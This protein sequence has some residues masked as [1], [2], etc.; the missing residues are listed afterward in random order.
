MLRRK[1]LIIALRHREVL[2][3]ELLVAAVTMKGCISL[4]EDGQQYL[5]SSS[6]HIWFDFTRQRLDATSSIP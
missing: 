6:C 4:Q 2:G 3:A 5:P 1:D